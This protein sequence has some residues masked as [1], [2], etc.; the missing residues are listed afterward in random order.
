[1]SINLEKGSKVDLSKEP[2]L[3]KVAIGLGWGEN[4]TDTGS[5]FDLDASAFIC[6]LDSNGNPK[7]IDDSH[8]V[9]YGNLRCPDG[10]VIHSG[11]NRDGAAPGDDE[12]ITVDLSNTKGEHISIVVTIHDAV[13]R[14]QNFGQISAS[15]IK[16]YNAETKDVIASYDLQD[17]FQSETAVQVGELYLKNGKWQF[18]NVGTGYKRG[19]ADFVTAYGGNVK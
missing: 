9:F 2:N 12:T 10:D 3:T 19:L 15:T 8:F 11:D 18:R 14:R 13:A 4:K 16:I 7:L 1:M 6:K 17:D 5:K